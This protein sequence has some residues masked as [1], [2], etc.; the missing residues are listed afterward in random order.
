M[1]LAQLNLWILHKIIK[2]YMFNHWLLETNLV[3]TFNE[4]LTHNQSWY[5][6]L[7]IFEC[8]TY[9][10]FR[11]TNKIIHSLHKILMRSHHF[12]WKSWEAL[13]LLLLGHTCK[14]CSDKYRCHQELVL[15]RCQVFFL[16]SDITVLVGNLLT[17]NNKNAFG[18]KK[19][20]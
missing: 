16:S 4:Q 18:I 11:L 17:Q 19:Q 13:I 7:S 2:V 20:G 15:L 6:D 10:I 8:F 1:S 14:L 5:L 3:S 9:L 12:G